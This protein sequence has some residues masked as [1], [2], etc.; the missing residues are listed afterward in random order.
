[1]AAADRVVLE[2]VDRYRV[3]EPLFEGL[4]VVLSYQDA[5]YSPA[6]VQGISGAA[7]RVAGIC[8]CAP[9]CGQAMDPPELARLMGY[10]ATELLLYG[11][12]IEPEVEVDDVLARVK[13]EIRTGRPALLWHAFT[14]CEWD[15]VCG[16][17]D[18]DG[19]FF[20]RGS[21][22]GLDN[23]AQAPQ[24]RTIRCTETCPPQGAILIGAR[25]GEFDAHGAEIAALREAVRHAHSERNMDQLGGDDWVMLDGL[26]CYDRWILDYQTPLKVPDMGDRYCHLV[27]KST[28]QAAA[29]FMAELRPRYPA[30]EDLLYQAE[31]HFRAEAEALQASAD[32]QFPQGKL[33]QEADEARNVEVVEIL[34]RAR[35]HYAQAIDAIEGA[36][37]AMD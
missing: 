8:P 34:Q 21:Y 5:P 24:L 22:R 19:L 29:A 4:R 14:S 30:A 12:G 28:R 1:M 11:E 16:Y 26:H 20:G 36:L 9:T 13:A 7:F 6:Y 37:A 17:D 35:H 32:M 27:Y 15:V 3:V 33:P 25:T 23:Y 2:G 10:E 18:M 31:I